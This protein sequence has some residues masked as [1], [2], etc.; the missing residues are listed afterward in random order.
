[1]PTV[2]ADREGLVALI[3]NFFVHAMVR[4]IGVRWF[5]LTN[6]CATAA[7][8]KAM[9]RPPA[10]GV[11]SLACQPNFFSTIKAKTKVDCHASLTLAL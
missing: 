5:S 2:V 10:T 3:N 1:M 9:R 6:N 8:I 11:A 4:Q 7:A